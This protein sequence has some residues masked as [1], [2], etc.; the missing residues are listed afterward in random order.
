MSNQLVTTNGTKYN[1]FPVSENLIIQAVAVIEKQ[2]RDRGEPLDPPKYT[3]TIAGGVTEEISHNATTL[4]VEGDEELTKQNQEIWAK[5]VDALARL[6]NEQAN[7]RNNLW[8]LRGLDIKVPSNGWD[9][10][11]EELFGINI[12]VDPI[13]RKLHY[14]MTEVLVTVEDYF[15]AIQGIARLSMAG[16]VS[17]EVLNS[18]LDSFRNHV[19]RSFTQQSSNEEIPMESQ[20]KP[21]RDPHSEGMGT[22]AESI[23]S[24]AS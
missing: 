3:V 14:I 20:L 4:V 12:P 10:E 16:L 22:N 17:Q 5:H 11:Q 8:L 15:G 19:Q 21:S 7:K 23:P 13:E 2:Y 18:R 6:N 9:K 24:S 1:L